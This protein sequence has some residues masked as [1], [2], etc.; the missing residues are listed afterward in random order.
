MKSKKVLTPNVKNGGVA[1]PLGN[2]KYY[3]K[4][5][6]HKDGGIGIGNND[7]TGLEVEDGEVMKLT[8]DDIRVNE[9]AGVYGG[10]G[11]PRASGINLS[12]DDI[13]LSMFML[14]DVLYDATVKRLKLKGKR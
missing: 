13:D 3:M 10:G 6:K 12:L 5:R 9:I 8:N 11:H 2:N 14:G 4:G 7:S 1:I